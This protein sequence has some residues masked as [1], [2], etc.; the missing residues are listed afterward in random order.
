MTLFASIAPLVFLT[1]GAVIV[2][3]LGTVR[4]VAAGRLQPGLSLAFLVTAG[5][6]AG[7]LW[8][9]GA[10]AF[11]GRLLWDEASLFL[12]FLFLVA[13]SL[14]I[15]LGIRFI[16]HHRMPGGEFY[17]LILLAASGL[18]IMTATP[19]LLTAF[20]GLEVFS[21]SGYALAGLKLGDD[22]SAEA[23]VKYFLTGSFAS[24][25]F[26]FGLALIYGGA[27]TLDVSRLARALVEPGAAPRLFFAGLAL[28]VCG[29]AYKIALVPFHMYQPDVYEGSP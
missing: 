14:T 29:L 25:F 4:K 15:L 23:A 6:C 11:G 26:V 12:A 1:A 5:I 2:L 13:A 24:A 10:R 27:K 20:L 8:G 7:R 18:V 17:G 28:A 3:L 19:D 21:V 16:A 9:R 22:R